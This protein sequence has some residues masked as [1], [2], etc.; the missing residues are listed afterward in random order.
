MIGHNCIKTTKIY[1]MVTQGKVTK[2][3]QI[4]RKRLFGKGNHDNAKK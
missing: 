4:L 3:M 2:N 1:A